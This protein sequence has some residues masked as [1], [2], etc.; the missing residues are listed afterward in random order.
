MSR[1]RI[2]VVGVGYLGRFHAQKYSANSQCDFV[3]VYD[4]SPERATEIGKELACGVFLDL[5]DMLH[6]VDGVSIAASTKAHFEIGKFFLSHGKHVLLEK[7]IAE[8]SSQAEELCKIAQEKKLVLQVGH[9]ERFNPTYLKAKELLSNPVYAEFN[10]SA[11]F[12]ARG[13]DVNVIFDVMIHDID[14]MLDVFSGEPK[15]K[16]VSGRSIVSQDID[17]CRVEFEFESGTRAVIIGDRTHP[18]V[19]RSILF[20]QKDGSVL[21]NLAKNQVLHS[22]R[23]GEYPSSS[24]PLSV[25]DL[26][27]EKVDALQMETESFVDC[28]LNG[29]SPRVSGIDGLRALKFAERVQQELKK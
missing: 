3:G 19:Q 9:I 7:P 24:E 28:V 8:N 10:R 29:K 13:A 26:P 5:N 22:K 18:E 1:P 21:A 15:I 2:G 23:V 17:Q 20:H 14:L 11:P 4:S 25:V 16:S 12:R 6:K 27:I